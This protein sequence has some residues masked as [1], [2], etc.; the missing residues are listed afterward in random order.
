MVLGSTH[1]PTE[2][3]TRNISWGGKGGRYVGLTTLTPSSAN[4]LEICE[5]Q[6]P[7]TLRCCTGIAFPFKNNTLAFRA[8]NEFVYYGLKQNFQCFI[9]QFICID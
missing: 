4:Y 6:P 5:S 2:I 9:N 7:G 3:S 1:P 8:L